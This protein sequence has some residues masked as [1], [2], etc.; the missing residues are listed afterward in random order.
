MNKPIAKDELKEKAIKISAR[1]FM[2]L[3]PERLKLT[4][5]IVDLVTDT[6]NKI[7]GDFPDPELTS[8]FEEI[9]PDDFEARVELNRIRGFNEALAQ[10]HTIINKYKEGE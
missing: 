4:A 10:V 8:G 1:H 6:L 9:E 5:E 7:E 2:A 3:D